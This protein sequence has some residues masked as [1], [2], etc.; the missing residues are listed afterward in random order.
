MRQ[1]DLTIDDPSSTLHFSFNRHLRRHSEKAKEELSSIVGFSK[2]E[3][4]DFIFKFEARAITKF[5]NALNDLKTF[6][7]NNYRKQLYAKGEYYPKEWMINDPMIYQALAKFRITDVLNFLDKANVDSKGKDYGK[8]LKGKKFL[9]TLK[10]GQNKG[11]EIK[12]DYSIILVNKE[13]YKR[14]TV[15]VGLTKSAIQK[16]LK[17]F[18]DIGALQKLGKTGIDNREMLYSDGY[19]VKYDAGGKNRKIRFLTASMKSGL[20]DFRLT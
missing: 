10:T 16:Y 3:Q 14:I 4:E 12:Y 1:K 15:E 5:Y 11:K 9:T 13:F 8:L 17:A 6:I 7:E 19:Y 18:C 20:R 2:E